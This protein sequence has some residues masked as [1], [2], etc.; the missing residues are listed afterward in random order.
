M[1]INR[2]TFKLVSAVVLSVTMSFLLTACQAGKS[3]N[4]AGKLIPGNQIL[5]VATKA[6]NSS[7]EG[8]SLNP[9]EIALTGVLS[10]IDTQSGVMHYMDISN[11]TEYEVLYNG[12]T[13]I[14]N[15]F[16]SVITS[17]SIKL[18]GIYDVVCNS[19]GTAVRIY[20]SQS[21]WELRRMDN[22]I[23]DEQ[24][25]V[26]T[27][28]SQNY[29]LYKNPVVLSGT[30]R[31]QPSEVM[32]MDEVTVRG[33]D[34][35]VYSVSVDK[36]H[37]YVKLTGIDDFVGGYV[38]IGENFVYVVT[39]DMLLTVPEGNYKV[40]I[41]NQ[42]NTLSGSKRLKVEKDKDVSL[43]FSEYYTEAVKNG[44][45]EFSVTPSGAVMYIDGTQV[46]YSS[47]ITLDYGK[48]IVS[49]RANNYLA[50]EETFIVWQNYEKKIID[51]TI[52][53]SS[54]E[55]TSAK[56]TSSA[57][58]SSAPKGSS[59]T[60][61]PTSGVFKNLCDGY[62]VNIKGPQGAAVYVN[63][64]YVGIAPATVDKKEGNMIITLT[65]VGRQTKSYSI[66]IPNS[67]GDLNYSFPEL[68]AVGGA[69]ADPTQ[70]SAE[71]GS[72]TMSDSSMRETQ[73]VR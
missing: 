31:I 43:D 22:F 19:S 11:A 54:K 48:H 6:A 23:A 27:I 45:V 66:D 62:S 72:A 59:S 16:D 10:Y 63:G 9:G 69:Q 30:D 39:K 36:G 49:L 17:A 65:M 51:M 20:E 64:S 50:Y 3:N 14:R 29:K 4:S 2:K 8:V 26:V 46:D 21:A 7:T 52:S 28:T 37:G 5:P 44:T 47:P 42:N 40:L 56:S 13:D 70:A 67:T 24:E 1:K 55:D 41:Q 53:Q 25:Q 57:K 68:P 60:A 32:K 38:D 71:A 35:M 34:K 12:G 33:I 61:S 58:A 18:G 73:P 15:K